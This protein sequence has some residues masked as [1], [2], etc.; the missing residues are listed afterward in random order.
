[1]ISTEP[2][3]S[4][5]SVKIILRFANR[6]CTHCRKFIWDRDFIGLLISNAPAFFVYPRATKWDS[7]RGIFSLITRSRT[8]QRDLCFPFLLE[9][10]LEQTKYQFLLFRSG[11]WFVWVFWMD[12]FAWRAE[13]SGVKKPQST[14]LAVILS[15]FYELFNYCKA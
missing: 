14:T 10:T 1:M 11:W 13:N 2:L 8:E 7:K 15:L 5:L 12:K 3:P 9:Q 6:K 4:S